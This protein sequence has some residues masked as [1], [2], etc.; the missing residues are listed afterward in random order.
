MLKG[1]TVP[2][3]EMDVWQIEYA[4]IAGRSVKC[5]KTLKNRLAT[6]YKCMHI[7]ILSPVIPLLGEQR[8]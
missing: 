4:H 7:L 8:S 1:R 6:S 2:S 5:Y 3:M